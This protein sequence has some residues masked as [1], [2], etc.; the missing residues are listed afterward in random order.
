MNFSEISTDS[1]KYWEFR[2]IIYNASLLFVFL[3][4]MTLSPRPVQIS[5]Y[6]L[7]A[8][9]VGLSVLAVVANLCYCIVYPID[10]FVQC[11][12]FREGWRRWRWILFCLGTLF[13]CSLAGFMGN[14]CT[15]AGYAG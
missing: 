15:M 9:G 8:S 3:V 2:R 5:A 4:A 7:W 6:F 14:V 13:A 12:E 11:S 10:L 1:I